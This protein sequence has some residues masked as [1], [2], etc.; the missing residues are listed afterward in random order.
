MNDILQVDAGEKEIIKSLNKRGVTFETSG[1]SN[2][3]GDMRKGDVVIE[4]KEI[5]DF[6]RSMGEHL[7]NQYHDMA[8][9]PQK[10]LI[11]SGYFDKLDYMHWPKMPQYYGAIARLARQG[12]CVQHVQNDT[13][14]VTL[15]LT[16][17]EKS[18]KLPGGFRISKRSKSPIHGIIMEAAPRI[19]KKSLNALL[20]KFETP[21]G[22]MQATEKELIEIPFI[23]KTLAKRIY[24]N[25]RKDK[26]G[27]LRE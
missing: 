6:F 17:M 3:I 22:V 18:E 21:M 16:I 20:D 10:W 1:H 23:G 15:A 25:F 13:Q 26:N 19:P 27:N 12:I 14:L 11:I 7:S 9:Y 5:N 2:E 24:E 8:Q 4:R